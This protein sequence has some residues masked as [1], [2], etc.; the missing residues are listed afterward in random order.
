[1]KHF[2]VVMTTVLLAAAV[3]AQAS[4]PFAGNVRADETEHVLF[5]VDFGGAHQS[6]TLDLAISTTSAAGGLDVALIDLDELALNGTATSTDTGFNPGAGAINVS[7]VTPSYMGVHQ[8]MVSVETFGATGSSDFSGT[9]TAAALNPGAIT[10]SGRTV[11]PYLTGYYDLL[12]RG[13][14]FAALST[15]AGTVST[16]VNVNFGSVDQAITLWVQAEA[17]TAGT[18]EVYEV[19]PAGTENLLGTLTLS[20]TFED[21][22]N[23]TT[24][25]R[26][27]T[28]TLRVKIV[29]TSANQFIWHVVLPGTVA[30][31]APPKKSGGGKSDSGGCS[32]SDGGGSWWLA[33]LVVLGCV[34]VTTRAGTARI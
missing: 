21:D 1:M 2:T 27:G 26:N 32:T 17:F 19:L 6:I 25:P 23:L 8:F 20:G 18:V 3:N 15:G 5:E 30:S 22:D 14:R 13:A 12:G 34:G 7:L 24:S 33:L 29:A 4:L 10:E 16:D 9:M 31:I 11:I 28:V